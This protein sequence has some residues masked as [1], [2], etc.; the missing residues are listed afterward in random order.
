MTTQREVYTNP[1]AM[2][3]VQQRIVAFAGKES[4]LKRLPSAAGAL[5]RDCYLRGEVTRGD[6]GRI[7]GMPERTA[8]RAIGR[9]LSAGLLETEGTHLPLRMAFPLHAV[10]YY[11]PRLYPEGVELDPGGHGTT[12]PH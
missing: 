5:L 6:A 11:F 8:R 10:G 12:A 7:L 1:A 4:A 9:M 2:N 3:E